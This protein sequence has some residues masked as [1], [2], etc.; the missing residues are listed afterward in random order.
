[1]SNANGAIHPTGYLPTT[2]TNRHRQLPPPQQQ[3]TYNNLMALPVGTVP[4]AAAA[5]ATTNNTNRPKRLCRF[6]GCTKTIKSQGHCQRHGARS[7]RCRVDG[8]EKQAQG[9]ELMRKRKTDG[10]SCCSARQMRK[11]KHFDSIYL[12]L[13][14][15][16]CS[17]RLENVGPVYRISTQRNVQ[18]TLEGK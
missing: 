18:T 8:C 15:L 2:A 14:L 4:P 17:S 1:M 10:A 9:S 12:C 11:G 16:F 5:V 13:T 6:P 7:K 3:Y